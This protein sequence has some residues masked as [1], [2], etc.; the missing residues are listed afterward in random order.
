MLRKRKGMSSSILET[1][2]AL[3]IFG[4]LMLLLAT[5]TT[6]VFRRGIMVELETAKDISTEQLITNLRADMLS[7]KSFEISDDKLTIETYDEQNSHVVYEFQIWEERI[8]RDSQELVSNVDS[9]TL[10]SPS[11]NALNIIV[12]FIDESTCELHL[13]T[14][15]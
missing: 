3:A 12:K 5:L 7:A 15:A 10:N 8:L 6:I 4:V 11:P 13:K 9:W 1:A 14:P 2:I